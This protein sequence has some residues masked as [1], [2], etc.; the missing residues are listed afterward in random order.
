MIDVD[1]VGN[2][3]GND[4]DSNVVDNQVGHAYLLVYQTYM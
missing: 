2:V 4:D 1:E 3:V